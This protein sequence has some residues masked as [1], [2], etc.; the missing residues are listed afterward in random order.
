MPWPKKIPQLSPEQLAAREGW[1]KYWHEVLPSKYGMIENFNHGFPA[2]RRGSKP[3]IKTLEIGAGL[4]EHLAWENLSDQDYHMLEYRQSWVDHLRQKYP[5]QNSVH[6]SIQE[7]TEFEE[8]SFDRVI[9]IHVLEHLP[10]LPAALQEISRL[11]KA[12]GEL[13][14]VIPCEG[15]MAYS[16][17]RKISSERMFKKKFKMEYGPIIAAEHLNT[18][19][20]IL[21]ELKVAGFHVRKSS[22]FPLKIPFIQPNL[23][24]GLVLSKNSI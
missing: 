5:S 12:D 22:F 17:A 15:G 11:L 1:M 24:I 7:K 23:C 19:K 21:R 10:D 14:V 13:Q 6:A 8:E 3:H 9:A 4:G 20:E 2:S 18:A 16:F